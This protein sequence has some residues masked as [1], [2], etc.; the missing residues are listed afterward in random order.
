M[1][2]VAGLAD[3]VH[4]GGEGRDS[5][6]G[7]GAVGGGGGQHPIG[8][9]GARRAGLRGWCWCWPGA[10]LVLAGVLVCPVH[11]VQGC[12]AGLCEAR[13]EARGSPTSAAA[14]CPEYHLQV[15]PP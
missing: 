3:L 14:S 2:G 7:G 13:M 4:L 11:L 1:A 10:R 5:G 12:S 8:V 15:G 6:G 9:V